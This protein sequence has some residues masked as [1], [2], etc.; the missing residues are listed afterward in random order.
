MRRWQ[1]NRHLRKIWMTMKLT[2]VIFFLAVAGIMASETYSQT[3][4]LTLQLKD[5]TVREVLSKIED[6]SEFFFLYNSKLVD[7][8]RKVSVEVSDQMIDQILTD[9]FRETDVVYAVVDR[10]I[11]LT[12]KANQSG[13]VQ[14]ESQ[15]PGKI[16]GKVTD[17]SGSPLPGVSVVVKGTTAGTI[18][19][20]FGNYLLSNVPADATLQ[21]SFVGMKSQEVKAGNQTVIN[22]ILSE[23][24]MGL[25]EVVVVG[26]GTQKK[27]NLTGSVASIANRDLENRPLPNVG[28]VLR[29]ISP[30]LNINLSGYGG[31]PGAVRDW[32]IRGLGSISGDDAPLILVDGVEMNINNLDPDNIESVSVLKD[33]SAS[34]IYGSRAPFGVVL[35]TTKKGKK[36]EAM[37]VQ[38]NNIFTLGSPLGLAHMENSLIFATA[39]NQAS[40]NT[41]S[42][43]IFSDEHIDRIKGFM[44]GTYPYEY[45]PDNPTNN[46]WAGRRLGN[47]N[48]DWPYEL[49]NSS[50]LDQKHSISMSGGS[51][52]TQYYISLGYYDEDGFYSVGYDDY[53]RYDVLANINSE[54]TDWL[55]FGFSAKYANSYTD[56]P[57]GITTVERRYFLRNLYLFGPNTPKY[58]PNGSVANPMLRSISDDAGRDKTTRNDFL[59]TFNGELEPIKGWKTNVSYS[60]NYLASFWESN[61]KPILVELGTGGFG[62]I[63]KPS[64]AYESNQSHSPYSLFNTV[65]SYE[66]ILGNHYFKVLAGFEQEEKFY[67]LQYMRRENLITEEIPSISTGL[68]AVTADD[69]KWDWATRGVFGRL[70][71]NFKEKY[72]MEFSARY[73]GSSRFAPE[74]RW[75]FFPSASAGY[76][77]SKENFWTPIERYVNTFKIRASYGSLGN[78]N[79]D[80]YLY[81]SSIPVNAETPWIISNKR[82]PYA[83]TPSLISQDLTWETITTFNTGVD[84]GFLNNRLELTFDWF[85]RITS[86]MFGPQETLPYTLGTG[87][88]RANN[89]ELKTKGFE[90]ILR[91]K[92]NIS[93]DFSY[94]VQISLGDNKSTI[95]KY[96]NDV[97][98]IDNWYIGKEVGEIWGFTTDRIIQTEADLETM[99]DQSAIYSVWRLGDMMYKD[100]TD[101]GKITTGSGTLSDHGD[102]SI[103]ANTS[104]RYNIGISGGFNWKGFDF[105]M[106]WTGLL[107]CDYLPHRE[108]VTFWGIGED[109]SES[110]ILKDSPGIDYWRPADEINMLGPNTD[111]YFAKPYF[112]REIFKNRQ[113]QSKYA[114]NAAYLRLKHIQ[115]GYTIPE[116]LSKKLFL[117][118]ARIYVSGANLLTLTKLP[119]TIDPE[120]S[121]A[122]R[123]SSD[124][125]SRNNTGAFYPMS[126]A[127]SIGLNVTF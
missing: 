69:T 51:E 75:G 13:F 41:G 89:A 124:R 66:K 47:A 20:A 95:L 68:G 40:S 115:L 118:E 61:P 73:N 45:D 36:G 53:K 10:Q 33:A 122:D 55:R 111:S 29:G 112:S 81:I 17:P 7:V 116:K 119:G 70:N 16:T 25:D 100:I 22:V 86:D 59:I 57:L 87:T 27:M 42:P 15:Q 3:A 65:T 58:N 26:Y 9:L 107:K 38:Y 121:L 72:L 102:L 83:T 91:W 8:D 77:I 1:K 88:P 120:S 64:A 82:P 98:D 101:D 108:D 67:S 110:A 32:N 113:T 78:Q 60:Y 114:L 74:S 90:M 4:R 127:F 80:S 62:N 97:G 93:S 125:Y 24:L 63:G 43:P 44:D 46:I 5:A 109:Y 94:N 117:Q 28:E 31:E 12:N 56:Y 35:I 49:L 21:F 19:D 23:E 105:S 126:R 54:V 50:K 2:I 104:P 92:D 11:V 37:R 30:N 14:I 123:F 106:N 84:A 6:N 48:Y 103:I 85:E 34:A 76:Q 96:K 99:P 52:K 71:Y 39:I 18:T 79:V